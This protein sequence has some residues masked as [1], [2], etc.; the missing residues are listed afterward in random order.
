MR[1]L[2]CCLPCFT[3]RYS[4]FARF[5]NTP[6]DRDAI[7]LERRCLKMHNLMREMIKVTILMSTKCLWTAAFIA[8]TTQTE[9]LPAC[10]AIAAPPITGLKSCETH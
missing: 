8:L 7:A 5:A 10:L 9:T 6:S 2:N 1:G 3:Y 4:R